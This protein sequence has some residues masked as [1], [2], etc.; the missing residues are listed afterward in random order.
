M[1]ARRVHLPQIGHQRDGSL[2]RR[3]FLQHLAVADDRVQRR[4]Q[5]VR[6][7]RQELR[8]V[9]ARVL[10]LAALLLELTEE[11]GVLDRQRGLAGER[12]QQFDGIARELPG[13]LAPHEEGPDY[14]LL[15][16]QRYGQQGSVPGTDQDV[17]YVNPVGAFRS[18][19]GNLERGASL[20]DTA[21]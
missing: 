8:L 11:P 15:T 4:A 2:V 21:S 7:V 5:L 3:V 20:D 19:V 6:H 16:Y 1:L 14:S 18:D 17:S 9:P 13:L 12:S 10:Q